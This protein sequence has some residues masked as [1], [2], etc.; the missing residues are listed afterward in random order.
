MDNHRH[1]CNEQ[2]EE[3][4]VSMRRKPND[5]PKG[6]GDALKMN[7]L[8]VGPL[9]SHTTLG[10]MHDYFSRLGEIFQIRWVSRDKTERYRDHIFVHYDDS[11]SIIDA[12]RRLGGSPY[13]GCRIKEQTGRSTAL[14][15]SHKQLREQ[16]RCDSPQPPPYDDDYGHL[17]YG[18][19]RRVDHY[20]ASN[21]E[22]KRYAMSLLE[23]PPLLPPLI[24]PLLPPPLPQQQ[25]QQQQQQAPLTF[26]SSNI[27]SYLATVL[28]PDAFDRIIMI[29]LSNMS[30]PSQP[31]FPSQLTS[32][33][34]L[35]LNQQP[36]RHQSPYFYNPHHQ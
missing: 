13:P 32:P 18:E 11:V 33:V 21:D 16:H 34:P 2:K 1:M 9:P 35:Y 12:E 24:P 31:A 7:T 26:D 23:P 6:R 19:D 27:L 28:Q 25:Q 22:M 36:P 8:F 10:K 3:G 4:E 17:D 30:L 29:L 5:T 14:R 20:I 15:R